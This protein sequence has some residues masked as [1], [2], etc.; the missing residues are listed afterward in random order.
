MGKKYN[1]IQQVH[2]ILTRDVLPMRTKYEDFT[3]SNND[4]YAG[5][6]LYNRDS[7]IMFGFSIVTFSWDTP[8]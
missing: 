8:Y 1:E 7:I 6:I 4:I 2:P 3:Y 5:N